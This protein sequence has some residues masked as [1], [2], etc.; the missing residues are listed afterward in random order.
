M[1]DPPDREVLHALH[2][3][4]LQGDRVASEELL[5]I[6]LPLLLSEIARRFPK[7]DEQLV[8]DGVT[9][10]LLDYSAS[11]QEF[12]AGKDIPLDRFLATAAWRNVANLVEGERRRKRR[13]RKV[14]GEQREAHVALDPLARNIWQEEL[15]QFGEKQEAMLQALGDPKDK[16]I[17]TLRLQ[18]VRDTTA[19]G[20]LLGITH[21]PL[22]RQREEVKRHKDRIARFLRRKGLLP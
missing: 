10:A 1:R 18:G 22:Q 11:P 8:A 7:T 17:W 19:F 15:Q 16:E 13:E 12:D 5:R 3:R 20:R 6:L 4:L 14:G 9:D 2:E 21:L